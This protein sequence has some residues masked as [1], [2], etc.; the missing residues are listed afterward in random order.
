MA[1]PYYQ[2]DYVILYHGDALEIDA[3]LEA[4]VLVTDPPYGTQFSEDNPRGGNGRR[5]NAAGNSRHAGISKNNS[6]LGFTT[7][8]DL[9]RDPRYK[10]LE[11]WGDRPAI[12][13]A[14][15]SQS[16]APGEWN[17]RLV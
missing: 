14:S 11:Q 10:A 9:I 8:N 7:Y 16:D 15:H 1:A 6:E 3:W 4:D 13:F 5:Q 12:V 2:D 17:V